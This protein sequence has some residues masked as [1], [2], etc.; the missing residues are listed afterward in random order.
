MDAGDKHLNVRI[1][2]TQPNK[3]L[4]FTQFRT[5]ISNSGYV[6]REISLYLTSWFARTF[7]SVL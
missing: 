4:R 2:V 3:K 6:G 7:L 1:C 5:P